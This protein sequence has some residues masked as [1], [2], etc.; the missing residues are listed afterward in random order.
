[1]VRRRAWYTGLG[2]RACWTASLNTRLPNASVAR[3]ARGSFASVTDQS[4]IALIASPNT[5]EPIVA[6]FGTRNVKL[7]TQNLKLRM[8]NQEPRNL[9]TPE[10]QNVHD[11]APSQNVNYRRVRAEMARIGS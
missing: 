2:S 1:M 9:G 10:P 5:A 3:G 11:I 6:P 4:R 8:Q 7:E